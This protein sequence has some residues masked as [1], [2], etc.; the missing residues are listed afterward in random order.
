VNTQGKTDRKFDDVCAFISEFS[1]EER[2]TT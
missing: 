2:S 1:V